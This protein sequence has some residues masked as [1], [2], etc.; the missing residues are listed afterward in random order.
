MNYKEIVD[1]IKDT[2]NN[3]FFINQF[4]YGDISDINT[5]ENEEPVNYPYAFLNPVSVNNNGIVSNFSFNLIIMT[6]GYENTTDEIEQQSNCIKYLEDIL[7]RVNN[8]LTNPLVEFNLPFS[9]TP[10]KERFSDDV[11]GATGSVVVTYPTP[12]NECESP[13]VRLEPR[14]GSTLFECDTDVTYLA[15]DGEIEVEG[16]YELLADATIGGSPGNYNITCTGN[17]GTQQIWINKNNNKVLCQ[18]I[19]GY[20]YFAVMTTPT[21]QSISLSCGVSFPLVNVT[22]VGLTKVEILCD[23]NL[24]YPISNDEATITYLN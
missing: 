10:F 9:I 2:C 6:Q 1:L 17:T 14:C 16:T 19:D 23:T 21:N 12:F 8:T 11:I 3:H 18:S 22:N 15:L 7:G 13:Y 5:P 4:G 24:Q 20:G